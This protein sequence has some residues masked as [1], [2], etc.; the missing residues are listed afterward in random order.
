MIEKTALS[1]RENGFL[2]RENRFV[3]F[4]S[5]ERVAYF[6]LLSFDHS[7]SFSISASSC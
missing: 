1:M 6:D 7:R 2:C 3:W 5:T 4:R